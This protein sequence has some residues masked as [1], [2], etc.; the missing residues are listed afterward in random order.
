MENFDLEIKTPLN[1]NFK[2]LE[3]E[4][5]TN[6]VKIFVNYSVLYFQNKIVEVSFNYWVACKAWNDFIAGIDINTIN[7]YETLLQDMSE[8]TIIC[9]KRSKNGFLIILPLKKII[10]T[11]KIESSIEVDITL[12]QLCIIK[13]RLSEICFN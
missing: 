3:F 1:L 2:I 5:R 10:K 12:E 13:D 9:I 6:S 7:S 4:E 8:N 11:I